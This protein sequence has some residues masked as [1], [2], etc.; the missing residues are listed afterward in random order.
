MVDFSNPYCP[1]ICHECSKNYMEI[2]SI[3]VTLLGKVLDFSHS[4]SSPDTWI[5]RTGRSS[6][7]AHGG[8]FL[9]WVKI[10]FAYQCC[11]F[12]YF[13]CDQKS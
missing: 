11:S 12:L 2:F 4:L 13:S 10:Y 8:A 1:F 7:M 6:V 9:K 5:V 3:F